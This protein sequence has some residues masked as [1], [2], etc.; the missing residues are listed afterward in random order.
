MRRWSWRFAF[1]AGSLALFGACVS[2]VTEFPDVA[3]LDLSSDIVDVQKGV[4]ETTLAQK[5]R[6]D[7]LAWPILQANAELCHDRTRR[8]YGITFGNDETIRGLVD[9]LTLK[10]VRA[11][12]YDASLTV[13]GVSGGSPA[14][15]AGIKPGAIPLKIGETA[16]GGEMSALEDALRKDRNARAVADK[17]DL[18]AKPLPMVFEYEGE[19]L[20]V[21]LQPETICDVRVRIRGTDTINASAGR[22]TIMI[23]RGI[24]NYL[25]SDRDLSVVIAHELGHVAGEH[26]R[27]LTRNHWVSGRFAWGIP[28]R[29]GAGLV[30]LSLGAT[31]ERFAGQETPPGQATVATLDN[32]ALGIRNF[33][34][35]ADYLAVYF[36]AR[37]G[38]ELENFEDLFT[39]LAPLSVR[40]TYGNR[41]HPIT[42]ERRLALQLARTE[43]ERKRLASEP[44]IP[45]GWPYPLSK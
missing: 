33:E 39:R 17:T 10:Q 15:E 3:A 7:R 28:L 2:A 36:A 34:R 27:K 31:L 26:V 44:L 25:E 30:D 35:E 9:G 14:A 22:R 4:V 32:R 29:V 38:I 13:I 42:S 6:I 45:T 8:A 37:A 12:G 18:V 16:I 1:C 19:R 41:S 43:V 20:E 5:A 11:I 24:A 40:S 21:A 23:N